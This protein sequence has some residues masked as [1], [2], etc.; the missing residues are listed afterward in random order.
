L[1]QRNWPRTQAHFRVAFAFSGQHSKS[2][3]KQAAVKTPPIGERCPAVIFLN[4]YF[5]DSLSNR[6]KFTKC[7]RSF[8]KKVKS[9][10]K[11][12]NNYICTAV[13]SNKKN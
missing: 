1:L 4:F 7:K 3:V 6:P 2:S 13:L 12:K 11:N 9:Y 8:V 5:K 10:K